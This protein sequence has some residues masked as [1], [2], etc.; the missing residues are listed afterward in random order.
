[1]ISKIRAFMKNTY[2]PLLM[3]ALAWL[4][5]PALAE[6]SD[7]EKPMNI[8]ADTLRHADQKQISTFTGKVVLTKGSIVMR[9]A[10]L[11]TRQD[12]QGNQFG[13]L[14]AEAGKRAYFRQKRDGLDEYIEG[15]A[16]RIEYDGQADTVRFLRRAE[17]RR[18]HGTTLGDE[19]TGSLIVYDN[20]T[21]AFS[22]D[23][24]AN[25][26]TSTNSAAKPGRVRAMLTPRPTEEAA[27]AN[28][29]KLRSSPALSGDRK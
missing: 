6:R 29:P 11:E 23:G 13:I 4:S 27:P 15:E 5:T 3:I 18:Y 21:D 28:V 14:T 24:V 7:R 19:I 17:L 25:A 9:G 22:V 12:P 16:E 10:V 1:M 8:E 20:K 26:N 2:A